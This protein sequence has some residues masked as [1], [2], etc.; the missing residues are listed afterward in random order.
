MAERN[1][2]SLLF[3]LMVPL[4]LSTVHT[5]VIYT[6]KDSIEIYRLLNE[7]DELDFQGKLDDAIRIINKARQISKER[8]MKR[9]EAY[10]CLKMADLLLKKS[11]YDKIEENLKEGY[12]LGSSIHDSL[13]MGLAFLQKSQFLKSLNDFEQAIV[14]SKSGLQYLSYRTDS[15]YI[16]LAYNEIGINYD[17]LGDYANAAENYLHALRIFESMGIEQEVA[18]TIGNLAVSYYR[19]NKREEAANLFKE[20]L[21]I[22]EKIGDVKGIAA[23]LGN[24][25][26]VYSYISLDTAWIYQKK[27]I[28]YAELS[29]IKT[30]QAQVYSNSATLLTRQNKNTDAFEYHEKA[31]EIYKLTG[32]QYKLTLQYIQTAELSE[33]MADSLQSEIFYEKAY[34][35]A[36]KL[37]SKPLL[38]ALYSSKTG[39]Y[40]KHNDFNNALKYIQLNYNYRDSLFN[41][42]TKT[43]VEELKLKYETEKKDLQLAK[44]SAE[45]KQ[46]ELEI[47]KQNKLMEISNL[48]NIKGQQEITLLKQDQE[49]QLGRYQ[50]IESEKTKQEL[51]N[52]SNNR[53]LELTNQNVKILEQDKLLNERQI[54]RQRILSQVLIGSIF[55]SLVLGFL[56]FNRYQ[57]KRKI[58]QQNSLLKIRN[59]I[60][61]DLHDEIGSTLTSINILSLVSS[62][63]LDKDPSQAKEM[64]N[65]ITQQSKTIQQNMSDIVWA[66][67]PDNEKIEAL[68]ARMRE[69]SGKVLE[70]QNI[71]VFFDVDEGLLS[72]ALPVE[73]RKEVL[74]IFKEVI[75]NIV[76]HSGADTVRIIW[77]QTKASYEL[78]ITDNGE[79]KGKLG[80]TGT[81]IKSMQERAISIGGSFEIQHGNEGTYVRLKIPIT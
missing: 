43:N 74:L 7:A 53:L 58:A 24:L 3:L 49:I 29:G 69:F 30:M 22:R 21:A 14:A 62:Q 40:K 65:Q 59:N 2:I 41:E 34:L 79:W 47:D 39:F 66:I 60:A 33:K 55:I 72:K 44:L 18:N 52:Q 76:K 28:H 6:P 19:L 51:I 17:K 36:T 67:R 12:Q 78:E 23:N 70:S 8:K 25:V 61:K 38:Q 56:L 5:Q 73:S 9:G 16:A 81:G 64:L 31:I 42:K 80:S 26:T 35:L 68:S 57:L 11:E 63:S 45:Q 77:K 27:A 54:Q 75:N 20:S 37:Q 4:W 15:L 10:A 13:I 71:K 50:K 1:R 48:L 46:R 32:D